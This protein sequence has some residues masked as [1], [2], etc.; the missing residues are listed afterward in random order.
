MYLITCYTLLNWLCEWYET[1]KILSFGTL[2]CT[3]LSV[4]ALIILPNTMYHSK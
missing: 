2:K 4:T 3:M 1:Y